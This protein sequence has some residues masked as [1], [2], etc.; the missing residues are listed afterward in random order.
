MYIDY[1]PVLCFSLIDIMFSLDWLLKYLAV[2]CFSLIDVMFSSSRKISLSS[3]ITIWVS[4]FHA[5]LNSASGP[6]LGIVGGVKIAR[7][8][9]KK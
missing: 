2:L 8:G 6:T 9:R 1:L 7:G 5:R 4:L 3:C